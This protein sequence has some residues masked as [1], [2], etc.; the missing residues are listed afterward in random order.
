MFMKGGH[1]EPI[2]HSPT[3]VE[4]SS[5]D[6]SGREKALTRPPELSGTPTSRVILEKVPETEKKGVRILPRKH[7][8]SH[9]QVILFMP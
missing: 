9:L 4:P 1:K 6:D 5:E 7:F 3:D 2:V 8:I